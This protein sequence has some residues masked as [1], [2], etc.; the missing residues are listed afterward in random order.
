MWCSGKST[1]E[2][3]AGMKVLVASLLL[4]SAPAWADDHSERDNV[5]LLKATYYDK[6]D[7]LPPSRKCA[8]ADAEGIWVEKAILEAPGGSEVR[9]QE[10]YGKKN[11]VFG[12]Y[13]T[14]WWGR[15][16]GTPNLF[17][18]KGALE[19]SKQQYIVTVAGM[20]YI[21]EDNA[22]QT[23]RLCFVST[24]PTKTYAKDLLM[25]ALPVEKN[26]PLSI[27]LYEPLK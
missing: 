18:A 19:A 21:Y 22:L 3:G 20:L 4:L 13:N 12:P 14:V 2:K 26:K 11:L 25:L 16:P 27:T 7:Q 9:D 1:G 23:S 6:F 10:K 24:A 17:A 5:E 8:P 15:I